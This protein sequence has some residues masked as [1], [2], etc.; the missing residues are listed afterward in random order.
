M[1][2]IHMITIKLYDFNNIKLSHFIKN[3]FLTLTNSEN[4]VYI[5]IYLC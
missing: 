3:S 4:Y 2:T 1:E 5:L